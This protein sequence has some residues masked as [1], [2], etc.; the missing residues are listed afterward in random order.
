MAKAYLGVD[1]GGTFTDSVSLD[2]NGLARFG[3]VLTTHG[4][5][6]EGVQAALAGSAVDVQD[7]GVFVHGTTLVINALLERR[8]CRMAL[9]TTKGFR[10]VVELGRGNRPDG[11]DWFFRRGTPLVPRHLRFEVAER[12]YANG[13]SSEP[14]D[15]AEVDALAARLR[16][17]H[18]EAVA[19][20]FLNAYLSSANEELVADALRERLPDVFVC[21]SSSLSTQWKEFERF[22]TASA[23]AYVGPTFKRYLAALDDSLAQLSFSGSLVMMDSTGGAVAPATASRQPVRLIESGPVGG[24]LGGRQLAE[25]HGFDRLVTFDMGGTTAK[26]IYMES[27]RYGITDLYWVGG[28]EHGLPLQVPCLDVLEIGAGGG[29]IAWRDDAGRLRVGPRSAGSTPGPAAYGRGGT[30]MTVT[31]ANVYLG[32]MPADYFLAD[33]RLDEEQARRAVDKLAAKMKLDPLRLALGVIELANLSMANLV[34]TQTLERGFDPRDFAL[35]GFGGAGPLH[36]CF[37]AADAGMND[38]LIPPHPGHFSAWG[39]LGAR[40]RLDRRAVYQTKLAELDVADL[41]RQVEQ[42]SNALA[43]ELEQ[44]VA[45]IS[46]ESRAIVIGVMLRYEGQEYGLLVESPQQTVPFSDDLAEQLR[47]AF[48]TDYVRRFGRANANALEIVE[49]AVEVSYALPTRGEQQTDASGDHREEPEATVETVFD[50][51]VAVPTAVWPRASLR[52]GDELSGPAIV[53]EIGSVT[54]VPPAA[55]VTVLSD[56]CLSVLLNTERHSTGEAHSNPRVAVGGTE[57]AG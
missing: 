23:N 15:M 56:G 36:A 8:G 9:V 1:I 52:P 12:T 13:W 18:V 37:V 43:A 33:F 35:L 49:V 11:F 20:A 29:S 28:Y 32:R 5:E 40:L 10:D 55:R 38:V 41:S 21:T 2:E 16:D 24:A 47:E 30:E 54:V 53:Y 45:L 7:I 3:K 44:D 57:D 42:V 26:S 31:D 14:P 50:D 46:S 17:V 39:M 25:R 27:K 19:V 34:R 51:G 6:E 22:T 4:R 48:E